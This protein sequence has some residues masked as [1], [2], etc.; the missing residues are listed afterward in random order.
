MGITLEKLQEMVSC[1]DFEEIKANFKEIRKE[2]NERFG[3]RL[4]Y[5]KLLKIVEICLDM[6]S[7][8]AMRTMFVGYKMLINEYRQEKIQ[9]MLIPEEFDHIRDAIWRFE[10]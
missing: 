8:I 7:R 6:N 2:L 10:E 1:E 5:R 3:N 9:E 4:H